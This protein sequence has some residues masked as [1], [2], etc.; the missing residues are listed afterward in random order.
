MSH[1]MEAGVFDFTCFH[2]HVSFRL[3][4][5][6]QGPGEPG[7]GRGEL[8]HQPLTPHPVSC[9][10]VQRGG[11]RCHKECVCVCLL[12]TCPSPTVEYYPTSEAVRHKWLPC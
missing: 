11:V 9:L 8:P 3:L 7:A 1:H 5:S 2:L 12:Q 6:Q 4:T 10:T